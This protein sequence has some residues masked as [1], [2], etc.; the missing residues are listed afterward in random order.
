MRFLLTTRTKLAN[1]WPPV[2]DRYFFDRILSPFRSRLQERLRKERMHFDI[3]A[4]ARDLED[5]DRYPKIAHALW[6]LLR[7]RA[8][9][10]DFRPKPDDDLYKIFAMDPEIVRDEVVD[11]ILTKLGLS[12]S[13]IDFTGFDFASVATPRD[14]MAFVTK[15][16]DAQN[17]GGKRRFVDMAR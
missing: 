16:A 3:E 5:G 4:F 14:V 11:E 13:G 17:G 12:V 2:I 7:D 9:V 6:E 10:S 1:A 8:F 15:V